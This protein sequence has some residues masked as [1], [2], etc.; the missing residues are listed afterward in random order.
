M[1]EDLRHHSH[2]ER[3]VSTTFSPNQFQLHWI[4]ECLEFLLL[5]IGRFALQAAPRMM[6]T[7]QDKAALFVTLGKQMSQ[8]LKGPALRI[9]AC[10]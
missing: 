8:V 1:I 9:V 10:R 4:Q 7:P 6:C 5:E 2:H 3:S